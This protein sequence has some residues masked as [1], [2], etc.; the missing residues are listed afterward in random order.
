MYIKKF[1]FHTLYNFM[2]TATSLEGYKHT[3]AAKQK[4]VKR[5]GNKINH[6]F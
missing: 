5:F 1:E 3:D 2:K 6:P 4:M